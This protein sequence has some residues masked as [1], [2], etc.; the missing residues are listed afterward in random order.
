MRLVVGNFEELA[1]YFARVRKTRA[2]VHLPAAEEPCHRIL[3]SQAAPPEQWH[4]LAASEDERFSC[5]ELAAIDL[6]S[7]ASVSA[8]AR[9]RAQQSRR[10][11]RA[12]ASDG[13]NCHKLH[14]VGLVVLVE[15]NLPIDHSPC[16]EITSV[17]T[18]YN[19]IG[20]LQ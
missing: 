15:G 12:G 1:S 4:W 7:L 20:Y 10:F 8:Y 5:P 6:R 18:T 16:Y 11:A 2:Y 3:A 17:I 14:Q 19:E 9:G 13:R